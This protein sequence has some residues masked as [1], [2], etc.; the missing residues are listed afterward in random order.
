MYLY[1][2]MFLTITN[3]ESIARVWRCWARTKSKI[4]LCRL[5]SGTILASTT[6]D[7]ST[8]YL[9]YKPECTWARS[10]LDVSRMQLSLRVSSNWCVSI[11][12]ILVPWNYSSSTNIEIGNEYWYRLL[13]LMSLIPWF[14]LM[15]IQN[16]LL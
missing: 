14:L 5:G 4:Q 15:S 6:I 11:T 10:E 13:F 3:F 8:W 2:Y 1:H 9:S 16:F 12:R 7:L